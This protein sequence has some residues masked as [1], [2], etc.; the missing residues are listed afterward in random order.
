MR[1]CCWLESV[2]LL[3]LLLVVVG[4]MEANGVRKLRSN[5]FSIIIVAELLLLLLLLLF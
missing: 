4:W 5:G 1:G 2:L 3:L